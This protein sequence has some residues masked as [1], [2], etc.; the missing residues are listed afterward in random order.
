LARALKHNSVTVGATTNEPKSPITE[1]AAA[2]SCANAPRERFWRLVSGPHVFALGDQAI[3]SGASFASMVIVARSTIPSQLGI[4]SIGISLLVA[5][6]TIHEA[7][8]SL[9]YT[10]QRQRAVGPPTESAGWSLMQ[11]GLFSAVLV[12]VLAAIGA[13]L[14]AS[15]ADRELAKM[16][17]AL[18][19]IAPFALFREFGRRFA[20]AHLRL[21][22]ATLL[23]GAVATIQL[24]A[25]YWLGRNGWMSSVTVCLAIG[26]ACASTALVW[27]YL[28]RRDIALRPSGLGATIR[29]SWALGK[30]LFGGQIA[31]LVQ[32]YAA[33][34][35]LAGIAGT[36]TAGVYAACVS[37]VSVANPLILGISNIS[38][39]R[40]VLALNDEGRGKLWRQSIEDAVLL[41]L[42]LAV[43][44]AAFVLAGGRI[45]LVFFHGAAFEGRGQ[46]LAVLAAALLA[47][48]MGMPASNAMA[49]MERTR[50]SFYIVAGA[51]I[52]TTLFVWRL[53]S[54]GGLVGAAY[55]VLLGNVIGTAAWWTAL[56]M[57]LQSRDPRAG[58]VEKGAVRSKQAQAM[59][60]LRQ[61]KPGKVGG[62]WSILKH[63]EGEQADV[64][65]AEFRGGRPDR[66]AQPPVVVK[67]YK[68]TVASQAELAG[69]QFESL[70][71]SN[72]ILGDRTFKGWRISI[73]APLYMCRSPLALIMSMVPGTKMS[74]HLRAG[75]ESHEIVEI[76]PQVVVA[77]MT[78]CWA[79]GQS[80]G[81]FD[82][83]N[84]L[85]DP[86]ARQISFVD[87]GSPTIV[88]AHYA[89]RWR[90]ASDDLAY[91]LY[92]AAIELKRNVVRPNL[93]ARKLMFAE[94]VMRAF[95]ETVSLLDEI[96]ARAQLHLEAID[97]SW[98]PQGQWHRLLR[99]SAAR[100]IEATLE[101]L[102]GES[103]PRKL[104]LLPT[105]ILMRH[106]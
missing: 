90:P 97:V 34:W 24:G 3:V 53:T 17:C 52:L 70:S 40:A 47:S 64:F 4:Y 22:Q 18:A 29:Q 86:V 57:V 36:A 49:S 95:V 104:Q 62:D 33:N 16:V 55:G 54:A 13:G 72:A 5:S 91:M 45:M 42:A 84:I 46:I 31:L 73:P 25:L 71:R 10:I 69:R 44:T 7:L 89:G 101:R 74:W 8:I 35:L 26:G 32:A 6:L 83:D 15:R 93:R 77:G 92:S 79:A 48:G 41:G 65:I 80:H 60:V 94:R 66:W 78:H 19:S 28:S 63:G 81:D 14:Y 67:L 98:S 88:L 20:F 23:D 85:L 106:Q 102:K 56:A 76:V 37:V 27:A 12:L 9:P 87:L 103:I 105:D 38:V 75:D 1:G 2:T 68:S 11:S 21:T 50:E 96:L 61:F 82:V 58:L 43:V 99:R 59:Q 39:P 30:W 51:A 100:S